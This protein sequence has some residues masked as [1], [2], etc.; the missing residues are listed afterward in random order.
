MNS[1]TS[2]SNYSVVAEGTTATGDRVQWL[3]LFAADR[4][5]HLIRHHGPNGPTDANFPSATVAED[6]WSRVATRTTYESLV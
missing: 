6:V 3:R 1:V 4:T 2:N 5:A